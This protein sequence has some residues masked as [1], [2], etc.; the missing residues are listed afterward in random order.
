MHR[1]LE[2]EYLFKMQIDKYQ[3]EGFPKHSG[4]Y[5]CTVIL[6]RHT[7]EV[8]R[9]CLEWWSEITAYTVSDQVSFVY[10]AIKQ[11]IKIN[12]IPGNVWNNNMF[13]RGEHLVKY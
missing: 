5:E 1:K 4:L 12:I 8:K 10:C 13:I 2:P 7:E 6:R 3:R 9:L 11:G